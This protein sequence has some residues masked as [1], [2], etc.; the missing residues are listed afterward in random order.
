MSIVIKFSGYQGERS[1]HTRAAVVFCESVR[2][3]SSGSISVEFEPNIVLRGNKAADLLSQTENG[4]IDGCYFSSSYLADRVPELRLFDQHFVV[5]D[6]LHAYAVLDGSLGDRLATEVQSATG[7]SVLG[8]WDNGLRHISSAARLIRSP[9][10]CI[11]LKIRCLN[12]EDHRRVFRSLG[13]E[14][15][16]IDVRDLPDAVTN[17]LVDAQENPLTNM[18]NFGLHKIQK[19]ITLTRHLLG[20]APVFFNKASVAGWPHE[21]REIVRSAV[22]DAT[23]SQRLFAVEDDRICKQAMEREGCEFISLSEH[24]RNGFALACEKEVAKTRSDF[25]QELIGL[26]N[27]DMASVS[28]LN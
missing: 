22:T 19:N 6:R 17:G 26:F 24:E 16:S 2:R 23:E 20:V 18:Y 21:V 7:L 3:Y 11:G 8:Y 28:K 25:S 5:P 12:S 15:I 1:V 14:A 13:F 9:A 27:A 10:D 4:Q